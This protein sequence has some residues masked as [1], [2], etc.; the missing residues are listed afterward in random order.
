MRLP[1]PAQ[2][3]FTSCRSVIWLAS[4]FV[5][6]QA[7]RRWREEWV[8]Q[9]WHWCQF[10][11]ETDQLNREK[12]LE[13]ARYCWSAFPAAFWLRFDQEEFRAGADRVRRSP[14]ICLGT[15]ALAAVLLFLTGGFIPALRSL[16]SSPIPKPDQLSV[17]SL[18]GSFRRVRSDTLLGLA[19]AWKQSK[20]LEDLGAFSWG[21]SRL[22]T[23]HRTIPVLSAQVAPEFFQVL[24]VRPLLGRSFQPGDENSCSGCLV[25][26]HELWRL[27]LRG[28]PSVIGH[29][30]VLDGTPRTIIGILPANF[31]LLSPSISAWTLLDSG[32]PSFTNSVE[33][34]GAIARVKPRVTEQQLK[35]DLVDLTEN[36]GYIFPASLLTVTSGPAEMRRYAVSYLVFV[37][38]AMGSAALVVYARSG[39]GVGR[40]PLTPRDRI[41]WWSFFLAKS[42]LLLAL[43]GLLAWSG[44]REVSVYLLGSVQPMTNAVALWLFMV[45]SIAPL[46]WAIRDQQ[47]RCRVCLRRLGTPIQIGALGHV[48]LD[49]SGTEMVCSQGHGVLYLPDSQANWLERDRW[50]NLDDS[51]AGLFK[52]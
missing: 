17:V 25:L 44:V 51:W 18:N 5:P 52:E 2:T 15:I 19:A 13:L 26:G 11:A 31:R 4:W 6:S 22:V 32:T 16:A 29:E 23:P 3:T 35:I 28:D 34:I 37:L 43:T 7:R 46:S 42:G 33:R 50:D 36:A 9:V 24:Q 12:K 47:R 20:L 40:A 30:I 39:Y 1:G 38:L 49:W 21:G 48:L 10:L 45:L 8:R 27:Q 14:G 41:R